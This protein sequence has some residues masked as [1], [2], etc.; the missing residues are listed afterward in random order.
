MVTAAAGVISLVHNGGGF[1][2]VYGGVDCHLEGGEDELLLHLYPLPFRN[3]NATHTH[4]VL[5][6][7][8]K[9]SYS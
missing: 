1:G 6:V 4:S 5:D 9:S 3:D 8:T 7:N 2:G